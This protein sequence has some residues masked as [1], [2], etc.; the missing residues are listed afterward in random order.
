MTT[1]FQARVL[2]L[3][4]QERLSRGLDP[5][6]YDSRLNL[7]A[8]QY[9]EL[10]ATQDRVG[11]VGPDGSTATDR[12]NA[13]GFPGG[14][15]ENLGYGYTSPEEV[16]NG[17]MNSDGHR[18][19]ILNPDYNSIGIGY[20]YLEND[21][22]S[23]NWNHYW[24]QK[25]G[26]A[27]VG[28]GSAP[29]D[30]QAQG[31]GTTPPPGGQVYR[32]YD[33]LTNTHFYTADTNEVARYS[34]DSRYRAEGPAFDSAG[35]DTVHRFHNLT[36]DTYFYTIS[37]FEQQVVAGYAGFDYQAGLGFQAAETPQPGTIPIYRFY[38][39]NSGTHFYTPSAAE[40]DSVV[41]NLPNY[42]Y[43]GVGFY[44]DPLG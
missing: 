22:G 11:H 4:N 18:A 42:R 40:R 10:L 1:E 5:L 31:G 36:T 16:V 43:E 6:T 25:F 15:G 14:V 41:A 12:A 39:L 37:D 17:W 3:T 8:E 21:T 9:S 35:A 20:F 30:L 19:N 32:F 13:A 38:E 7:A 24:T 2:E 33:F 28:D 26:L 27:D 44:A 29:V 23:E 34:N